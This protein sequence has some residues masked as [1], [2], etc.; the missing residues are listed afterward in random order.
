MIVI[1]A[2]F[3]ADGILDL[4]KENRELK[5]RLVRLERKATDTEQRLHGY[6]EALVQ[7]EWTDL[8]AAEIFETTEAYRRLV[9]EMDEETMFSN[10]TTIEE[11]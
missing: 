10:D 5:E 3:I 4:D 11:E 2:I 9:S 1:A 8:K 6:R 7:T